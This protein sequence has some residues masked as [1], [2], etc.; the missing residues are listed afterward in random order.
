MT[1]SYQMAYLDHLRNSAS[2]FDSR[3]FRASSTLQG[4]A[5][6]WAPQGPKPPVPLLGEIL[7]RCEKLPPE[8]ALEFIK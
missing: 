2:S 5:W 8:R 1:L 6:A 7:E 4:P 3:F